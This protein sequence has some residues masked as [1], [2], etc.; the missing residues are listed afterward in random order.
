MV[1]Y[2]M[3]TCARGHCGTGNETEI[4]FA[5]M[6]NNMIEAM[7]KAKQMPSVKHTRLPL[8]G[9]EIPFE[10]YIAYRQVNAYERYEQHKPSHYD[11]SKR[12]IKKRKRR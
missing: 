3:F 7:D 5:I 4:K 11:K 1:K 10:E 9:K 6:A 2:Y 8:Y 12:I